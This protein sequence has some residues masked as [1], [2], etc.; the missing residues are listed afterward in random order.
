[1]MKEIGSEFWTEEYVGT[2]K[3]RHVVFSKRSRG[4]LC[5]RGALDYIIR[6]AK[7]TIGFAS[8]LLPSYCCHTMIEPFVRNGIRIRFY[9]V[10]VD[11]NGLACH[12][13]HPQKE[14]A[15]YLMPYFGFGMHESYQLQTK[16]WKFCILDETHC[17]FSEL[18]ISYADW[19]IKYTYVSYRKW[20]DIRGFAIAN[21]IAD[22]F[23]LPYEEKYHNNY[24]TV[25]NQ[26]CMLKRNYIEKGMGDK[27]RFL[28]LY[29]QSEKMLDS[30]YE[31]Y[32]SMREG[33]EVYERLDIDAIR[34]KRR[35]NGSFLMEAF[36]KMKGIR[37]LYHSLSGDCPL[38][39]PILVEDGLRDGLRKYLI[40]NQIYCP[41]HW[42][43]SEYLV[44]QNSQEKEIYEKELSVVCDQRYGLSDMQRIVQCISRFLES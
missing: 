39:I 33:V 43:Q 23:V 34:Q 8:V 9:P 24:L 30:D 20:S 3:F 36:G 40:D 41:V 13:P 16:R 27:Q 12:F 10:T 25:K 38:F 1:M 35:E 14:E 4:F 2:K 26:A 19:N 31:N 5:G 28:N 42:P 37:L 21:K 32:V 7:Q 17:C 15:L 29:R 22:D 6:D 18:P 11:E 44:L